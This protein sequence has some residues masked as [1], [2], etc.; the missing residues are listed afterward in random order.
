MIELVLLVCLASDPNS[1]REEGLIYSAENLT[2]MQCIMQAPPQM[3]KWVGEHPGWKVAKW[4]C[5]RA[6]KYA[7]T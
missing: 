3:A 6:G 5:R 2:P 4:T 1:C 7:K